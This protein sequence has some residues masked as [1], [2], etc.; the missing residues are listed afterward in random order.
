MKK[1]ILRLIEKETSGICFS[2]QKYSIDIDSPST[3][4]YDTEKE[5]IPDESGETEKQTSYINLSDKAERILND[6]PLFKYFLDGSRRVYKIDDISYANKVYPIIAGQI[7]I[8]CCKR[9]NRKILKQ[10]YKRENVIVLPTDAN[11]EGR[12][13]EQFFENIRRQINEKSGFLKDKD[14]QVDKI[15]YY[16]PD[17]DKFGKEDDFKDKAVAKI[18]D[19]M[20]E[21]EKDLVAELVQGNLLNKDVYL[22][23][24]GSLEYKEYPSI[25]KDSRSYANIRNNYRYV[26]GV[27]KSFNPS[28]ARTKDKKSMAKYIADLPIYSRT[29]AIKYASSHTGQEKFSIWYLRIRSS[30]HCQSPFDGVIKVEKLLTHEDEKEYGLDSEIINSISANLINE[31]NPV[32]YGKDNRWANHLYPIYLT[33]SFVKS[34]YL[35]NTFFLNMF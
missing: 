24:D 7:G 30:E 21:L 13:H 31:R 20:I 10:C 18:Q 33:E 32:C 26:V 8:G 9:E 1:E 4:I 16:T 5:I 22:I 3:L 29:P 28:L 2:S 23:K 6:E 34:K 35:S 11:V 12:R 15:L 25:K 27:S 17:K 14:I 19:R